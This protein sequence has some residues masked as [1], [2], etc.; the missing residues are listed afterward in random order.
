MSIISGTSTILSLPK[1]KKMREHGF[2]CTRHID[3]RL[4]VHVLKFPQFIRNPV[5]VHNLFSQIYWI[6]SLSGRPSILS[7][8]VGIEPKNCISGVASV[9]AANV[10]VAQL[11]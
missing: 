9:V 5:I 1:R 3:I 7:N 11:A 6:C 2:L 8:C 10:E 4:R